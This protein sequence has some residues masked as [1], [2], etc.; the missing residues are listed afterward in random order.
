V[1]HQ[2]YLIGAFVVLCLAYLIQL[3]SPLRLNTDATSFLTLAASFLDGQGFM[4][5]GQP[6]HFPVGYPLMLAALEWAGL[7]CSASITG[8]N[9]LMLAV[10]CACTVYLLRRSF[11]LQT[12]IIALIGVLTLMCWVFVKHATLPLSDLPYFGFAM[13]CLAAL[14]W[15]TDQKSLRL[16]AIGVGIAAILM[17]A[18]ILVRTVGIA[19]I[20]AFVLGCLPPIAW[21]MIPG[22]LRRH[23][24]RS[25]LLSITLIAVAVAGCFTVA[26]TRYFREM[27]ADWIG[28]RALARIRLEDWTE[29]VINTSIAKLPSSLQT[30]VCVAGAVGALIVCC[31]A[32]RR[33]R[34]EIVDLY[35]LAYAAILVIWPYR[36]ARFWMPIFPILATYSWLAYERLADRMWIRRAARAYLATFCLMGA[37]ALIYSTRISLSGDQFPE[38]Y[39]G[40]IYRETYRALSGKQTVHQPE[41]KNVDLRLVQLIQRYGSSD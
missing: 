18:A 7:A 11:N 10:G 25:V 28:W 24:V 35:T 1:R 3:A 19:L 13:P 14:T 12:N 34:L 21:G 16:R 29:L 38:L 5:D 6:T 27:K 9:L 30:I 15:S 2:H 41:N 40:G 20:P 22:W 36:D 32:L 33:A 31:G 37:V 26:E 39:G 8:V 4:I 23:P 17:V